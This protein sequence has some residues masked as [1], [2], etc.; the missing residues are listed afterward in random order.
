MLT[1]PEVNFFSL[2]IPDNKNDNYSQKYIKCLHTVKENTSVLLELYPL[3]NMEIGK[4][5]SPPSFNGYAFS[6]NLQANQ[7]SFIY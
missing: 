5:N 3:K 6:E 7:I 4:H 1:K 2:S